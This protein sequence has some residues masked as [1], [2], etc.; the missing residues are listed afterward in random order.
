MPKAGREPA[1]G[2]PYRILSFILHLLH[3]VHQHATHEILTLS[4][5]QC[6]PLVLV[7]FDGLGTE[8]AQF[9]TASLSRVPSASEIPWP[10]HPFALGPQEKMAMSFAQSL[11][12]SFFQR[13]LFSQSCPRRED[14]CVMNGAD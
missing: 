11:P 5:N 7:V 10:L 2:Y 3:T 13:Q 6:A 1:Q 9:G 4:F 8:R 12:Y 14:K